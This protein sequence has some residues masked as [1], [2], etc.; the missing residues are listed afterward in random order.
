MVNGHARG[1]WEHAESGLIVLELPSQPKSP[2]NCYGSG[3]SI[4]P[5]RLYLAFEQRPGV[6]LFPLAVNRLFCGKREVV[7]F[8]NLVWENTRNDV[9]LQAADWFRDTLP[10]DLEGA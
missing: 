4:P 5:G 6:D 3:H 2:G 10:D 7:A 8:L 1:P 9:Y